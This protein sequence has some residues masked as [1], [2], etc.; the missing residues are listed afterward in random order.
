MVVIDQY[1]S[2]Q[3]GF[4]QNTKGRVLYDSTINEIRYNNNSNYNN[5]L[6]SKDL[7]NDVIGI[8]NVSITGSLDILN[9]NGVDTG[10][11]LDGELVL[12]A[13]R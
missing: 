10:L 11:K 1:N 2:T 9:F 8:N 13:L 3:F 7:S 6:L 12:Y 4:L 5:I